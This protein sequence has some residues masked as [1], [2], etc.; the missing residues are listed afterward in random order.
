MVGGALKRGSFFVL[1]WLAVAVGLSETLATVGWGHALKRGLL[2]AGLLS[3]CGLLV[4]LLPRLN[5]RPTGSRTLAAI[6][7]VVAGLGLLVHAGLGLRTA[8]QSQL[9]DTILIDQGQMT[10]RAIELLRRGQDPWGQEALIDVEGVRRLLGAPTVAGCVADGAE[11]DFERWWWGGLQ[12]EA[13]RSFDSRFDASP[14]CAPVR[15]ERGRLGL[16]YGPLLLAS[17]APFVG[18]GKAGLYVA[19]VFWLLVLGGLLVALGR[20]VARV[21]PLV[22][23]LPLALVLLPSHLRTNT[24]WFSAGDLAP[25]ALALGGLLCLL[26]RRDLPAGLLIGASVA[27]K[28]MPGLLFVPLLLRGGPRAWVGAAAVLVIALAGPAVWDPAGAWANLGAF[29]VARPADPTALVWGMEP[30]FALAWK[31]LLGAGLLALLVH[32]WRGGWRDE[33]ALRWL[34][35]SHAAVLLAGSGFHN[36]YMVWLLPVVGL[37]AADRFASRLGARP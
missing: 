30:G 11:A 12:P 27:A 31:G 6:V 34:L 15:A 7:G 36:N 13:L 28:A 37:W 19:H 16:K 26:H 22:A 3:W 4:V 23:V 20:R 24:L 32:C 35:V 17:Y 10:W 18:L 8:R 25:V 14:R 29:L 9:H 2:L 5:L 1:F 21:E 33:H